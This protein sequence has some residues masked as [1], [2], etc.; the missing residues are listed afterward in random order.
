MDLKGLTSQQVEES[1]AKNGSNAIPEAEP[2]TFLKEFLETF[3]DPMIKILLAIAALMIVMAIAGLAEPYEPIGTIVAVLIVAF[4]SAK[5][6]VASDQKYIELK[7]SA[8][9]D[10]CK[11]I[12]DGATNVIEVDDVVQGDLILLQSGDK[13]PAD[14]VLVHGNIK[15]DNSALNGEA[16]ECKKTAA[17]DGFEMPTD[18]TGDTFVDEHSLFRGAVCID[19]EGYLDVRQVGLKTMM[20]KMAE[21]MNEEEPDSP[22]KVKLAK[23]ANQISIFGYVSAIIIAVVYIIYFIIKAGGPADFFSQNISDI[24]KKIVD[25]VSIAILIVVCAV[26]EGLPLMISLV[27][28]QNTSKMLDH[29]VLVRKAVGIETAGSLNVLFSDKTGTITKGK[30]E[31]VEFFTAD[32]NVIPNDQLAN[33]KQVKTLLDISIGKNTQSL[34]DGNHNVIGGNFTDQALMHFIGEADFN[35]LK[36]NKEYEVTTYQ[37]F[38]SANKFSQ[39]RIDNL[40]KTFYK[41]APERLLAKAKKYLD[42]DGNIKDIDMD[43]LNEKIDALANKAMRV[44]SFGYSEKPM[45]ENEINDDVV[46]IGL[47][48]IRDDVRAEA[49]EAI[50][51]VQEAGIQ[52]V[53]ITGDRLETAKAIAKD[54]GLIKSDKDIALSSAEL[55]KMSD[56][57]VKKIVRDIRV[58]ARALPTDKSRMVRICQEMNLVVGMTGDGVNDSPAL[59]KADVGFAMGSGTEAAKEA[60]EIVILDDNF[61]SIK[62]AI[63][64]GRTIYNNILKFCKFQLVINV[65][66]VLVSAFGPFFGIE[67][68]LKVTHLLFVNLV[69]DGLGAIMLGNEPALEKYMLEKPRRRDESIISKPMAVQIGVMGAWLTIMSFLFFLIPSAGNSV[70]DV[71]KDLSKGLFCQNFFDGSI[72]KLKTGYFVLFI[73]SAL[74]NGF[75]V[76]DQK[77]GIFKGLNLNPGFV[78]VMFAIIAVQ[79][80]I[81]NC[82]LIPLAPF[83]W[84]GKMFSCVP[85]GIAGWVVVVLMALTM[86]P[87]DLIR[88]TVSGPAKT[89]E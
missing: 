40:G 76:R 70:G 27:L 84:L 12:R 87:V 19:G 86:I 52:V 32:G 33:H 69:M 7:E 34:F 75:N 23:L 28:M 58:I 1:R 63:L 83:Q 49:K 3:G 78:K 88:K 14:G 38:N 71:M 41:G 5:T 73:V 80:V 17:E 30:L 26:P 2:T 81:V 6:N 66:A 57:E 54:A 51:E 42:A 43:K 79:A 29:N 48:G 22:L 50:H 53:M 10:K 65:A 11:A 44:L 67:E 85:F 89:A 18:I 4:V 82:G 74:A 21:E 39:S 45:V 59:K 20:G 61:K 72:D 64:Y 9:K 35:A 46:I 25:G 15:V 62:D 60:G 13:I 16:E 37:G 55:N 31:V 24:I 47:V 8:E 68:P 56:D 36:E 77:Y